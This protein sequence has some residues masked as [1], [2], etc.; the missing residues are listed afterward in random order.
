MFVKKWRNPATSD[1]SCRKPIKPP[2]QAAAAARLANENARNF[3]AAQ[4]VRCHEMKCV[5]KPF[6]FWS[7]SGATATQSFV[8]G[9]WALSL[10][11]CSMRSTHQFNLA[12]SFK[13]CYRFSIWRCLRIC[14]RSLGMDN[15]MDTTAQIQLQG[16]RV[17]KPRFSVS[18]IFIA[19][20]R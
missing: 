6:H 13:W 4:R 5:T 12:E 1:H 15:W 16:G 7:M 18:Q 17:A 14:W 2:A 19:C 3:W 8:Q 9:S 10:C 20:F 11:P